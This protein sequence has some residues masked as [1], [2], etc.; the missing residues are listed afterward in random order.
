[1]YELSPSAEN[2]LL[3]KGELLFSRK[4]NGVLQGH[5]HIGNVETFEL[6]TADDVLEKYNSMNAAASL[7]KRITRRRDVTLRVTADEFTPENLAL[8]LMG[9]SQQSAAQAATAVAGEVLTEDVLLGGYYKFAKMGPHTAISLAT[10]GATADVALVLG[11][12]YR[13]HDANVGV[14]QILPGATN[15]AA[16]ATLKASYTPTAYAS[17]LTEVLGGNASVVEG[18]VLFLPDP[19]SGPKMMVEVWS[20]SVNPDGALGLISDEFAQMAMTMAVQSDDEG[21]PTNPLYKVTYVPV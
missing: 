6:T 18:S 12:D 16:G 10:P 17:G 5:R 4:I 9:T 3:G 19:T 11:T 15:I 2:L 14:V 20:V 13:I 7:Y 1:M 8:M 21:H